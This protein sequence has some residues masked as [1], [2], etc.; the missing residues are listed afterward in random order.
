M[1]ITLVNTTRA[2]LSIQSTDGD[3]ILLPIGAHKV[4]DK[5]D[6]NLPSGVR[7]ERA[8]VYSTAAQPAQR[9]EPRPAV[10]E[11]VQS[12]TSFGKK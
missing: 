3:S 8:V 1:T 4:A 12:T 6:W 10:T 9:S 7:K 2:P 5:F 11:T